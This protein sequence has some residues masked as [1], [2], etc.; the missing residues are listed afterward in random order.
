MEQHL[1]IIEGYHP[2]DDFPARTERIEWASYLKSRGF[3]ATLGVAC[4]REQDPY[5]AVLAELHTRQEALTGI[6]GP[7]V[8]FEEQRE[9]FAPYGAAVWQLA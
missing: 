7:L 9:P 4:L 8:Y 1:G 3:V 5:Q 2:N 6:I